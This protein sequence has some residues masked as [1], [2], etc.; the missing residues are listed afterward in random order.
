MEVPKLVFLDCPPRLQFPGPEN[1]PYCSACDLVQTSAQQ[2]PH[3]RGGSS[4]REEPLV[5]EL[6]QTLSHPQGITGNHEGGR[7]EVEPRWSS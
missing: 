3:L 5:S 7:K 4:P 1:N 2:A 6:C